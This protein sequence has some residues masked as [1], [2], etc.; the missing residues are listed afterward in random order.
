MTESVKRNN[1]GALKRKLVLISLSFIIVFRLLQAPH[2]E[3]TAKN[4][5]KKIC[6]QSTK[7]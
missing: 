4:E 2:G 1:Q 5:E 6:V 7:S 3:E